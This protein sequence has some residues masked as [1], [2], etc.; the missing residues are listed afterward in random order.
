MSAS[1]R[2]LR[3]VAR[4]PPLSWAALP[5]DPRT[6]RARPVVALT[7][8]A[9][10]A[11]G[12]SA[13]D[14]AV[15]ARPWALTRSALGSAGRGPGAPIGRPRGPGWCSRAVARK[16]RAVT[17]RAARCPLDRLDQRPP[18]LARP[19]G[20]ELP[21]L[22]RAP[23]TAALPQPRILLPFSDRSL[24]RRALD[25]ALRMARTENATL[26]P[27]RLERIP[28]HLQMDASPDHE[29]AEALTGI[30]RRARDLGVRVGPRIG[31]GRS[32]RYALLRAL[33]R[34]RHDRVVLAA[35]P[36]REVG[37]TAANAWRLGHADQEIVVATE[38][39]MRPRLSAWCYTA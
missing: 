10:R 18:L 31:H 5:V 11:L 16:R 26:V 23:A 27:A 13:S 9:P 12:S 1:A 25:T 3:K 6:T 24:R 8:A 34:E 30:Q 29:V 38:H 32:Y 14:S 2:P 17:P 21:R 22:I 20:D 4:V 15:A 35:G 33:T 28:L 39:P 37:L 36:G 7:L 19:T